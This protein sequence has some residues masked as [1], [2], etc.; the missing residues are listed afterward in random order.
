M[1][2]AIS[3]DGDTPILEP[4]PGTTPLWS[5]LTVRALFHAGLDLAQIGCVLAPGAAANVAV[6]PVDDEALERSAQQVIQSLRIGPRLSIVPAEQWQPGHDSV[7]LHMGLAFG[8]GQHPTTKLCLR[9]LES[10]TL[11]GQAVLDY[12]CGT[13]VLALAAIKL[14]AREAVA[15]DC[16]PQALDATRRNAELNGVGAAVRI[17]APDALSDGRF[18]LILANILAQPLI[19]LAERFAGMQPPGARIV[20]SGILETQMDSVEAQ[21]AHWYEAIESRVLDEW[22]LLIGRRR[23]GYDR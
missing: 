23:S 21:Y 1:S 11:D 12:G 22:V 14:G 6:E 13:G 20:L 19:D 7:G 18:D 5:Q 16:E 3:D 15:I 2:V 4:D 10:A 17:G 9:W 8:T